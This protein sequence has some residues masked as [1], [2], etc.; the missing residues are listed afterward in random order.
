MQLLKILVDAVKK[1]TKDASD[2][3]PNDEVLGKAADFLMN[4]SR[5]K[6][7]KILFNEGKKTWYGAQNLPDPKDEDQIKRIAKDV[8]AKFDMSEFKKLTRQDER[9]KYLQNTSMYIDA[10]SSRLVFAVSPKKVIKLAGGISY[11]LPSSGKAGYVTKGANQNKVEAEV[12]QN[13]SDE[14]RMILPRV[15]EVDAQ[16]LWVLSE[17]VRPLKSDNELKSMFGV[18]QKAY[19]QFMMG[20]ENVDGLNFKSFYEALSDDKKPIADAIVAMIKKFGLYSAD[21]AVLA[22][23][24]KTADGRL[25]ILDTGITTKDFAEY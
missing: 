1:Q 18:D 22:Q 21:L 11:E 6:L 20:I 3:E 2:E 9:L 25:V 17:L 16:F 7:S 10:G 8:P 13:S 24:G 19:S 15:Y 5:I 14:I 12:W 23:W 4:E